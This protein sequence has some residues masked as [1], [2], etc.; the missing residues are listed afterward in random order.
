MTDAL[1]EVFEGLSN[2]KRRGIISTLAFRPATISQLAEEQDLSL[3]A[4]H[5]HIKI[6]EKAQLIQRR[7]AGRQNFI[8]FNPRTM[9]L[10]QDWINQY[11]TAWGSNQETLE[12]YISSLRSRH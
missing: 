4:I 11:N 5:K 12:N 10:A 7:K 8:A 1:D 9:S 3:P 2:P 6:L